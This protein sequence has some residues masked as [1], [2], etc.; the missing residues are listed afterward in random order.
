MVELNFDFGAKKK[1]LPLMPH[2]DAL[3]QVRDLMGRVRT[4]EDS[5][6]NIRKK[7]QITDSNLISR[8][9]QLDTE[10]KVSYTDIKE[11]RRDLIE[12]KDRVA[13]MFKELKLRA[14]TDDVKV[15]QRYI[16]MWEPVKFV[17]K[18]EIDAIVEEKV[19][20]MLSKKL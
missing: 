7:I 1:D 10:I 12:L 16:D 2:D 5:L 4:L 14:T 17:T 20:E 9:K 3:A 6:A 13:L 18:N 11:I 15:L 8:S 19:R